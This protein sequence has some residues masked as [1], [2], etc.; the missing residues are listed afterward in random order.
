MA[1]I[2]KGLAQNAVGRFVQDKNNPNNIIK[3]VFAKE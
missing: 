3:A 2:G 1:D